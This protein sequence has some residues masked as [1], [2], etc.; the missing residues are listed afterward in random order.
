MSL[1]GE[2]QSLYKD[3]KKTQVIFPTTKVKAVSDDNGVGL[4]AL[5]AD[6]PTKNYVTT[7]I[8]EAQLAG[9][10]GDIDL[11]GYATKDDVSNA[12]RD[13][14]FPVDS[15]NG[16]T[17][18]ITL[19]A[20]DIGAAPLIDRGTYVGDINIVDNSEHLHYNSIIW[21]VPETVNNLRATWGYLETWTTGDG[22]NHIQRATY[23][24]HVK[25]VRCFFNGVWTPWEW[26]NPPMAL[27]VEYRTTERYNG[28]PVYA[29]LISIGALP[30]NTEM[31]VNI[32]VDGWNLISV[33]A[34]AILNTTG[35]YK[36]F[37]LFQ[38]DSTTPICV[39]DRVNSYNELRI[40]ASADCSNYYCYASLKHVKN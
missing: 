1:L 21:L 19:S 34:Y 3:K 24:D 15:V 6:L 8:A 2:I 36:Q 35:I 13:I 28:K 22:Y 27:G 23:I 17:G 16:K 7:K 9:G 32:G 12:V 4:D 40:R 31:I 26:K 29:K 20:S 14:D 10:D 37:P 18:A 30:N 5:L 33:D 39:I 11:S 38:I 25:A